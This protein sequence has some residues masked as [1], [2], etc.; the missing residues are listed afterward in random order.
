MASKQ[1]IAQIFEDIAKNLDPAM[2]DDLNATIQFDLDGD[3][4]G[5]YWVKVGEGE[6]LRGSGP[7]AHPGMPVLALAD[8]WA[9]LDDGELNPLQAF[10]SGRLKIQGNMNLALKLQA[11]LGSA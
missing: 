11:L 4:G 8:D 2:T 6:V 9:A 7:A 3:S 10:M 1:E 5:L